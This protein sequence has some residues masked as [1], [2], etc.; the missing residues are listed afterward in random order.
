VVIA[1]LAILGVNL[2]V[3]VVIVIAAEGP[4]APTLVPAE[5][6]TW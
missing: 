3:L 4:S 5:P 2:A 1:L 6:L